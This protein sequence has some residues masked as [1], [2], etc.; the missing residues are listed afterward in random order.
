[1]QNIDSQLGEILELFKEK[2]TVLWQAPADADFES[3]ATR[4]EGVCLLWALDGFLNLN[5][6]IRSLGSKKALILLDAELDDASSMARSLRAR[7]F[8]YRTTAEAQILKQLGWPAEF[9]NW[10]RA[11]AALFRNKQL[12]AKLKKLKIEGLSVFN[13]GEA[14]IWKLFSADEKSPVGLSLAVFGGDGSR[15]RE[16]L[17]LIR[18]TSLDSVLWARIDSELGYKS[19]NP[20]LDDLKV[21]LAQS[22]LSSAFDDFDVT[23]TTSVPS[24]RTEYFLQ[25]LRLREV[26]AYIQFC[27]SEIS[28]LVQLD[29][30]SELNPEVLSTKHHVSQIDLLL[31]KKCLDVLSNPTISLSSLQIQAIIKNR[32]TSKWFDPMR[33]PFEALQHGSL[34]LELV[35]AFDLHCSDFEAGARNYV[36]SWYLVDMAYRKFVSAA[37]TNED[38]SKEFEVFAQLVEATYVNK[39]QDRL[40]ETWQNVLDTT[41]SWIGGDS[42]PMARNFFKK[43]VRVPLSNEK[44]KIAVIISD[45][46]RFEIGVEA[47]SRLSNLGY[48]I[49][50]EFLISP[51]PSYTQLGMAALLPNTSIS[52]RPENKTVIVDGNSSAGLENRRKILAAE[53]GAAIDFESLV[54]EGNLKEKVAGQRLWYIYHNEID[55]IGDNAASEGS[56]FDAVERTFDDLKIAVQKLKAAGFNRVFISA[57]HGFLYQD[58]DI[59]EHGF[60]STVPAGEVTEF[61]NRRFIIG[62]GLQEAKGLKHFTSAQL[63]YDCGNE[64]QLP[65]SSLRLRKK[66]SGL[67]FVH[68]GASLQEIV[69]PLLD[70]TKSAKKSLAQVEVVLS[71]GVST[72]ITTGIA[73]LSFTQTEPLSDE[74]AARELRISIFQGATRLSTSETIVFAHTDAEIRNRVTILNLTMSNEASG[75]SNKSAVLKLESRIGETERWA[76]YQEFELELVNLGKKDF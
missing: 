29:Q 32:R 75:L 49:K 9:E 70:L 38:V 27:E 19:S 72:K 7:F 64:V 54:T 34:I 68:G 60:L 1:M 76:L 66:G 51:L 22:T 65:A 21:W 39:F 30:L 4:L 28:S 48:D 36:D 26:D 12:L 17:D 53:G 23:M 55:K 43:N 18:S 14:L 74:L 44:N 46:M 35:E 73:A 57:D 3:M 63:G 10:I 37:K 67:R 2:S 40:G 45:A 56:V 41:E 11:H 8:E 31:F 6:Q 20:S 16:A 15:V 47:S 69:V 25:E 59:P 33:K 50:V 58:S 71:P 42:V 62:Q 52:L 5:S 24:L 61:T 13:I